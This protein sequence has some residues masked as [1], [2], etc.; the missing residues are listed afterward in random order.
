MMELE[1]HYKCDVRLRIGGPL[2]RRDGSVINASDCGMQTPRLKS[3]LN[4]RLIINLLNKCHAQE[5][6]HMNWKLILNVY[7]KMFSLK[8]ILLNTFLNE[9]T[10]IFEYER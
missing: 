4:Q 6:D 7:K 2:G 10:R 8:V 1:P 5:T 9:Y 3:P